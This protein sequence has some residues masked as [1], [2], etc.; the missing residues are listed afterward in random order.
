MK[1]ACIYWI[2]FCEIPSGLRG[3]YVKLSGLCV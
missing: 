1:A 3:L 2:C